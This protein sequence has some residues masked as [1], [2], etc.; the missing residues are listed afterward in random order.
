MKRLFVALIA[1]SLVGATAQ[2][3]IGS[4]NSPKDVVER[5]WKDATEGKLLTPEGWNEASPLFLK[6]EAFPANAS[7]RIVSNNWGVDHSS[8]RGDTAEV[9][10][11]YADAGIVDATLK[12]SPPSR[13]RSQKTA[14]VFHLVFAP[15]HWTMFRS[16]GK[17]ITGKEERTG[18]TEWQ[19]QEP[20]GLPWT[21]VNT[22]IRYVLEMRE[23]ATDPTIRKNADATL[24]RL[25]KL[26]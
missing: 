10:M 8:V 15:T 1:F 18:A 14:M 19:I 7:V 11:G 24:A 4:G 16:D 23:K 6:H 25:L 21:T 17:E 2:S 5:L 9:D 3:P 26:H 20:V 13:A 12:Y 22:A